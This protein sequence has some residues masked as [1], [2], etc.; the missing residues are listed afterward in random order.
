LRPSAPRRLSHRRFQWRMDRGVA[1]GFDGAVH[2]ECKTNSTSGFAQ[3]RCAGCDQAERAGPVHW[4]ANTAV[5][6]T[7][8][9]CSKIVAGGSSSIHNPCEACDKQ[10]N[11]ARPGESDGRRRSIAP[12]SRHAPIVSL[13]LL[14]G[15]GRGPAA[16]GPRVQT[17]RH[18]AIV[19]D[20]GG[21]RARLARL[22]AID[23]QVAHLAM[24]AEARRKSALRAGRNIHICP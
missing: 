23:Y 6:P 9:I 15:S 16:R 24:A 17:A 11:R 2:S 4:S 19:F 14:R 1:A 12:S 13:D 22:F 3:R 20:A 7:A 5:E 10:P 21:C 18:R 8:I